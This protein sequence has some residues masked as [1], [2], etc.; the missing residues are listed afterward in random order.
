MPIFL[1][2]TSHFHS[3]TTVAVANKQTTIP[4]GHTGMQHDPHCRMWDMAAL[5]FYGFR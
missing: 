5:Y 4:L 2:Q 3:C 1:N